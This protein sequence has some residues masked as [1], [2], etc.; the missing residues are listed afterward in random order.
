M[1]TSS[2]KHENFLRLREKRVTR[3]LDELRLISQL[4]STNY[5]NTP[6]EAEEIIINL[7]Q[8]V[9]YIAQVFGVEFASRI[10]KAQAKSVNGGSTYFTNKKAS[11]LDEVE[12]IKALEH[13][14]AGRTEEVEKILHSSISGKTAA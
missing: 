11:V 3:A 13:L 12:I 1:T 2:N 9:Q 14:R 7:D 10:G 5:E 4:S 6:Q 8:A